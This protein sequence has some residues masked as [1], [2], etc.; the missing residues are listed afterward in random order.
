MLA[1]AGAQPHQILKVTAYLAD[2]GDF[3]A[4][5]MVWTEEFP[6]L[7]PARMTIGAK[8][9]PLF[10]VELD[11]VAWLADTPLNLRRRPVPTVWTL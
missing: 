2:L 6:Q 1:E 7:R 4:Y 8:L 10:R 5:N 11:V 3:S 9:F